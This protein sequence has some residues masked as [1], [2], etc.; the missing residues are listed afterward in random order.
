MLKRNAKG[1]KEENERGKKECGEWLATG[2]EIKVKREELDS[3]KYEEDGWSGGKHGSRLEQS[4]RSGRRR[5]EAGALV[6]PARV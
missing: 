4:P 1:K 6:E 3:E 5:S 2:T